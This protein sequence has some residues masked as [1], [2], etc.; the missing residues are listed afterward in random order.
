[1]KLVNNYLKNLTKSVAYAAADVAK[2]DLA[3]N[4]TSFAEDNKQFLTATYGT[5]RNPKSSLKKSVQAIQDSKV[6][7]A[8]DYGFKNA[9]EDL[10]TGKWYNKE[11]EQRDEL[12]LSGLGGGTDWDDLSE[13]GIDSDWES[14]LGESKSSGR[15]DE[16]TTGDLEIVGAIEDSNAAAASATVNAVIRSSEA[17]VKASRANMG[18][19][20]MQNERL[21]G[22][23]HK[24]F[25]VLNATMD[26]MNKITS[27][28][29]QNID[30]NLSDFFTNEIKLSTERNAI[31]KEMLEMQRNMYKSAS[32]REKEASNKK[33][34]KIRWDDISSGGMPNFEAYFEAVKKNVKTE[35]GSFL[36]SFSDDGNMLATFFTS[37]LKYAIQPLV[38]GLIPATVKA[39]AKEVDSTVTGVFSNIIAELG[40]R[41]GEQGLLG[42]LGK[43]FGV[44]TGVNKG[45][46]TS[47]YEKGPV[48]FDG[49]TRKAIIDVIPSYLRR[50]E[51]Y[52]TGNQEY[53]FDYKTGKW[54]TMKSMETQ[55]K[56]I[57]KSAVQSGTSNLRE[58]MNPIQKRM[59]A[60]NDIDRES[61]EKAWSEFYEFMF[62]K[63]GRFN[64][65][66]SMDKN[67][68]GFQY[69]NFRRHYK[70]IAN[71]YKN[72]GLNTVSTTGGVRKN[73]DH[74]ISTK[75]NVPKDILD[76]KGNLEKQ[77]RMLEDS[78]GSITMIQYFS[79][80]GTVGIDKH[81]KYNKDNKFKAKNNLLLLKDD[82]GYNVYDYLNNINKELTFIRGNSLEDLISIAYSRGG[83]NLGGRQVISSDSISNRS[84]I[85]RISRSDR[86]T[87]FKNLNIRSDKAKK[88]KQS[89]I[90]SNDKKK[91]EARK[92][93]LDAITSGK[94]FDI[95]LIEN[96]EDVAKYILYL[97]GLIEEENSQKY[98]DEIRGYNAGVIDKFMEKNIY[99]QGVK[100]INDV[101]IAAEKA[102]KEAEKK[103]AGKN[104]EEQ[105]QKFINKV[106]GKII[107]E[108]SIIGGIAGA[109]ADAFTNLLYSADR[110]IYEM[111]YKTEILDDNDE[112][113]KSKYNGFMDMITGKIN[114]S[115]EKIKD[116]AKKNLLDPIKKWLGIDDEKETN[117][118]ER[119]TDSLKEMGSS[120]WKSFVESNKDT[121]GAVKDKAAAQIGIGSSESFTQESRRKSR[122]D[123]AKKQKEI[124]NITN[125]AEL[126]P[127]LKDSGLS[128]LDYNN[129]VNAAKKA[130]LGIYAE[131]MY[132]G[133]N[134]ATEFSSDIERDLVLQYLSS[135]KNEQLRNEVAESMG[136][137]WQ[138]MRTGG[139][140]QVI[141]A[142]RKSTNANLLVGKA[143]A[144]GISDISAEDITKNKTRGVYDI[145]KA[146]QRDSHGELKDFYSS[147]AA[148]KF[149]AVVY[150]SD[151]ETRAQY[152]E[153]NGFTGTLEQKMRILQEMGYDIATIEKNFTDDGLNKLW[154]K[155]NFRNARAVIKA[156]NAPQSHARGTFGLPF[157]GNTMLSK[158]E[159]VF[160]R[161]GVSK[162]PKTGFYNILEP[163]HIL[164]SYDSKR[165]QGENPSGTRAGNIAKD[166][167][168]EENI[169]KSKGF[170]PTHA[171]GTDGA[172]V[173]S[174]YKVNPKE[175]L[176]EAKKNVPEMA[177]GGLVGG[178]LSLVL[179]LVGGPL[180]GAAVGAGASL[181]KRSDFLKDKLFGKA[182]EDGERDGGIV[183]KTVMDAA[184][185]Y[186]PDMK[187]FGLAGIIPG[188]ITPLGPIGGLLAG[189]AIGFAKNNEKFTN[190][191]FGEEGKLTLKSREKEIIEKMAPKALKGAGIGAAAT[192]LGGPFGIVGNAA[193]GAALGIMTSSVD[194]KELFLGKE[195]DG[196]R[197]GGVLGIVKDAFSPLVEAGKD[198]KDKL[199]EVV[200]KNIVTPI[201]EFITP[202]INELPRIAGWLPKKISAWLEGSFGKS[203]L[204]P[205]KNIVL[206][207]VSTAIQKVVTPISKGILN[208]VTSP[209]KLLGVAGRAL[210]RSQI[211]RNVADYQTAEERIRWG[212]EN[213]MDP[214]GKASDRFFASIGKEGGM[215]IKQA[216]NLAKNI[217]ILDDTES[218][219]KSKLNK[220]AKEVG[221]I[222][223]DYEA[224]GLKLSSKAKKAVHDAVMSGRTA[225]VPKILQTYGLQGS[226]Q[227]LTESQLNNLLHGDAGLQKALFQMDD[228]KSRIDAVRGLDPTQK[229]AMFGQAQK[230]LKELGLEDE[231][232]LSNSEDRKKFVNYLN[233][234]T[235][236][237][238]LDEKGK[239]P[240]EGISDNVKDINQTVSDLLKTV[241]AM[242]TGND[243]Y[244]NK[245]AEQREKDWNLS[246]GET[247]DE[248]ENRLNNAYDILG[249]NAFSNLSDED[250]DIATAGTASATGRFL[251]RSKMKKGRTTSW[252]TKLEGNNPLTPEEL[253]AASGNYDRLLSLKKVTKTFFYDKDAV[254]L[255]NGCTDTKYKQIEKF[256]KNQDLQKF[257]SSGYR[258]TEDDIRFIWRAFTNSNTVTKNI[259]KNLV[260]SDKTINDYGSLESAYNDEEMNAEEKE[261]FKAKHDEDVR[262][263]KA[264]ITANK[265]YNSL[266]VIGSK[267]VNFFSR[268][269][270]KFEGLSN[271]YL[272]ASNKDKL[273]AL[274]SGY[275]FDQ[276][277]LLFIRD[278]SD[279]KDFN[280]LKSFFKNNTIKELCNSYNITEDDLSFIISNKAIH[281]ARNEDWE[282]L[283]ENGENALSAGSIEKLFSRANVL[284]REETIDMATKTENDLQPIPTHGIGTF[285]L[286]KAGSLAKNAVGGLINKGKEK[287]KSA[288]SGLFNKG[289]EKAKNALFNVAAGGFSPEQNP[290]MA[291]QQSGNL[292]EV[293]KAGDGKDVTNIG[294][295]DF[296]QTKRTS[297]GSVEPDTTDN[298]TK[299]IMNRIAKENALKEKVSEATIKTQ[300]IL[301]KAFDVSD[302]P[303]SKKGKLKW[304]Q[305]LLVGGLLWKTGIL[306][307]IFNGL[308]K[309]LWTDHL[310]PWI[311]DTAVPWIK[312][313]LLPAL[314]D[315]L[316]KV[317]S[318]TVTFLLKNL[319][320]II[321][322]GI[323]GL[324]TG[325]D[326]AVGNPTNAGATTTVDATKLSGNTKMT[327]ENGK[328]LSAEDIAKG[329][330]KEIYNTEGVKGTVNEDGTVTFKDASSKG[331]G[332]AKVA[333]NAAA[334]A[335]VN[336]KQGMRASKVLKVAGKV[337]RH[338]PIVGRP[339]GFAYKGLGHITGAA[340]KA[341]D[342]FFKTVDG[343]ASNGAEKAAGKAVEKATEEID[344]PYVAH[345]LREA[346]ES[347]AEKTAG[348]AVGKAAGKVG[349]A[350]SKKT[351]LL[352]KALG[353]LKKGLD[354]LF[355]SKKVNSK[356]VALAKMIKVPKITE[357]ITRFKGKVSK[358][359][360]EAIEKAMTKLGPTKFGSIIAKGTL[361]KVIFWAQL[362]YDFVTGCD[363]AE[364]ILGVSETSIIEEVVAGLINAICNFLI[365][366]SIIP[367]VPAIAQFL[368][369][370]IGKEDFSKRQQETEKEYQKF[371]EESGSTLTKEEWLS[372][373]KS[374]TGKIKG[375]YSDTLGE[376]KTGVK[377]LFTNPKEGIKKILK[378]EAKLSVPGTVYS[379][380]KGVANWAKDKLPDVSSWT[381]NKLKAVTDWVNNAVTKV[382]EIFTNIIEAPVNLIK[383]AIKKYKNF[384]K[385]LDKKITD[386]I[387]S[388]K[389][390]FTDKFSW[391]PN[392]LK[393]PI[394]FFKSLFFEKENPLSTSEGQ[395]TAS[396]GTSGSTSFITST[397]DV[398]QNNAPTV[399]RTSSNSG[400]FFSRV[401]GGFKSLFSHFGHGKNSVSEM[402][403]SKQTDP[404]ISG[405]RYN[406][407]GDSE[408]QTIG[409]SG[410]GPAAAVNALEAMYGRGTQDVV[411]AAN[412]AV[413]RGYKERDGG[414]KPGFFRDYFNKHGYGSQTTS[415]KQQ[416]ASNIRSGMPTVLMGKDARG[417]STSTPYGKIPHYV[418]VTGTD[419]RGKAIVQDPES[420]YDN[421]LYD[422][423]DL[424]KKSQFGVSTYGRGGKQ[425]QMTHLQM[426]A[427]AADVVYKEVVDQRCKHKISGCRSRTFSDLKKYHDINCNRSM[428]L[429]LQGAGCLPKGKTFGHRGPTGNIW[430][431]GGKK[432]K[433]KIMY[434][435]E[436]LKNCEIYKSH[437]KFKNLPAKYKQK[438][439]AYIYNSDGAVS[440]GNGHIYSCN[441]R[442]HSKYTRYS[443]VLHKGGRRDYPLNALILYCIRPYD[444][445]GST[446]DPE[447]LARKG[448]SVQSDNSGS[449][450]V[451]DTTSKN[452]NGSADAIQ[453]G[454]DTATNTTTDT[455]TDAPASTA[456]TFTTTKGEQKTIGAF[457]A[458]TLNNSN[459]GR[460]LSAFT[461]LSSGSSNT[462]T[463]EGD[464]ATG[465][466]GTDE[467]SNGTEET[468]DVGVIT[469]N[470]DFPK[471]NLTDK[472]LRGVANVVSHEQA[473]MEGKLAEASLAANLVDKSGNDKAT[474][475]N[476]IDKVSGRKNANHNSW[477]HDG[478]ERYNAGTNDKEAIAATKKAIVE[479][480]RTLP[481]YVDEHDSYKDLTSVKTEGKS[482]S[483]T[484]TSAS[485]YIPHK[486]KLTNRWD[487]KYTFYTQPG[488]GKNDAFGYTSDSLRKKWGD[489]HYTIGGDVVNGKG[490]GVFKPLSKYGMGPDE[491]ATQIGSNLA[492]TL[493]NSN[494]GRVLSSV[495]DVG[496]T[497][498]ATETTSDV[499]TDN[500]ATTNN[501]DTASASSSSSGNVVGS[502]DG[503]DVI[504]AAQAELGYK[505][506]GENRTKF[507]EWYG[508]NGQP[509]CAMFVS[510]AANKAGIPTSIIPKYASVKD[511][512]ARIKKMGA[513]KIDKFSDAQPG[514]IFF[515]VEGGSHT[516]LVE[517]W[518]GKKLKTIEGNSG[519]KVSA[520]EYSPGDSAV[521]YIYRPNY[522]NKS[523]SSVNFSST[524]K[525]G[526][527]PSS[528]A[529]TRGSNGMKPMS[530]YGMFKS[531][532]YGKGR[533][534][535]PPQT[536]RVRDANGYFTIE[537]HPEDRLLDLQAKSINSRIRNKYGTGNAD[538]R[539]IN[540]IINILYSIA[541]NTDKLNTIVAILNS[542]LGTKITAKDISDNTGRETL[543][544]RLQNSL[545][546]VTNTATSKMNAYADTVGDFS[547]NTVIQAMNAIASE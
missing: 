412:F 88:E 443:Q 289:K 99:N 510:W 267:I 506:K 216:E 220:Q 337:G 197:Q 166:L 464:M 338:I 172:E 478:Y 431:D 26:S 335:F 324:A 300:E 520:R 361:G 359:F 441:I 285:L 75:M 194:F 414:T 298:R 38:K 117:L 65:N 472:Q 467:A 297:D 135:S 319:P 120:L 371:V 133:S 275:S 339:L 36:P 157:A 101:R 184:K 167:K 264:A 226:G 484:S 287:V 21:F 259:W 389:E 301:K 354:Y 249:D 272:K 483:I 50:I 470:G 251:G 273:K 280:K 179:G 60:R 102:A 355:K 491:T 8:L 118:K 539:L 535:P 83:G 24:D 41:R 382:K 162:V 293:D 426:A 501:T 185:K 471:Y 113:G 186:W 245:L 325:A 497:S 199:I 379:A 358:I 258:V 14:N 376:A 292:D 400:G 244:I 276:S 428:D 158:G 503:A 242:A 224:N 9:F 417:T 327:D 77:Y 11:R 543:K 19:I 108:R 425:Q 246:M 437:C 340:S 203:I 512:F 463:Q 248:F 94:A 529:N 509:W 541:D 228:Y 505:E 71:A 217:N 423:N 356:L 254:A 460:V 383:N 312:N 333:G 95:S 365:I 86:E 462:T 456:L 419:A 353:L 98:A 446:C 138:G 500:T 504:R 547:I 523:G 334:H 299:T 195:I 106:F 474:V 534:M 79:S 450:A 210:H 482:V 165:F 309:P 164:N 515:N 144:A 303:A 126:I 485:K 31:L 473:G 367:G 283:L 73:R 103:E 380:G 62:E 134:K 294:G 20:Y 168:E 306:G 281:N 345:A 347:K 201:Q 13:F 260:K 124:T 388:L 525:D 131:K 159:L 407:R 72:A 239:P 435:S 447:I 12:R 111:M 454:V 227:G 145:N 206:K 518:N 247:K 180:A 476:L 10:R 540:T 67:D 243:E 357:W 468:A 28:S 61:L 461:D 163:S 308:I 372:R 128:F 465:E 346:A 438:G 153:Q 149:R 230:L 191:Y 351:G 502:G 51:A 544:S 282:R 231:F 507:G 4:V 396:G 78:D 57:H 250:K 109:S 91:K 410:C 415:S 422:M 209:M 384:K 2:E 374:V 538:T 196:E 487:A 176:E 381:K 142:I 366:P 321:W 268:Q 480:K 255:I 44:N 392:M 257:C 68:V 452:V 223:N 348:K 265:S 262:N 430:G 33:S 488:G 469:G 189:A 286:G 330:Y 119:F 129:D 420:K 170:I 332:F 114:T 192:L 32:D 511:G 112:E 235:M 526:V 397:G 161:G 123:L 458:D 23:L 212:A 416:L 105:E 173:S 151:P 233:T 213:G 311:T 271:D 16:I 171:G 253:S 7:Q 18:M 542:K 323:K 48:P 3:P 190:K 92:K 326:I 232:D 155:K 315:L 198:F 59:T 411:S 37:P 377:E 317:L 401:A 436:R 495:L 404:S 127:Y 522:A 375:Y 222:L 202:F 524:T 42:F 399:T 391:I 492:D 169:A 156:T 70:I 409:N 219:L 29:L 266:G 122:A 310:K 274:G 475:D 181:I 27:A 390:W 444:K 331:S 54:V 152:V 174:A 208:V 427:H 25:S 74:S 295:G 188:L 115:F 486:T 545:N 302:D 269:N 146:L 69:P 154:I 516:G 89:E 499:S 362:I 284:S 527:D 385:N 343:M 130:L 288:I 55:Y 378:S 182:G 304:W 93:A 279:P 76:A 344:N 58:M 204:E 398:I 457:L 466:D 434:G 137:D 150:N 413:D 336:P 291:A 370:F 64:P 5:L 368:F 90:D 477:F 132:K 147:Q 15:K 360:T 205:I 148:N 453:D 218:G 116:S 63:N 139:S 448:I 314:G 386:G 432:T 121:W 313:T 80:D 47:K 329:N 341:G 403:Y 493:N 429:V 373:K 46:D 187:K 328:I 177:A 405:I 39:A 84:E 290:S 490:T 193:V 43:I 513:T 30:K 498:T 316:N 34:T 531:S 521:D 110:A 207:P 394:K 200:D 533:M 214:E 238:K 440:A 451:T 318:A 175:V 406:A 241:V 442:N 418:T 183:S 263:A 270:R 296:I 1:M 35:M 97:N 342:K 261:K 278:C 517:G 532:L 160:G 277:G 364:S 234:E 56:N 229:E 408:Y 307:K 40:N 424:L 352:K 82:N 87:A 52:M 494:I 141:D 252:V 96:D 402:G 178:I 104:L 211:K 305:L 530:K 536:I 496:G 49:I 6:F 537:T 350:A 455:A 81:G 240:I 514:D 66:A 459:I 221:R 125:F 449:P 256:I 528:Y 140:A 445:P 349:E 143:R 439:V 489:A 479:G 546:N 225:D 22:G 421:Q 17:E 237:K 322:N 236:H 393:H 519:D 363:Q 320:S 53:A 508:M 107:G 481:R 100:S 85:S 215:S 433:S 369:S 45:I 387:A 136:I 395:V